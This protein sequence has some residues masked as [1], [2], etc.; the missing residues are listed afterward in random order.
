MTQ[1]IDAPPRNRYTNVYPLKESTEMAVG[2]LGKV[3]NSLVVRIPAAIAR[4]LDLREGEEL[5]INQRDHEIIV[6][7]AR[8]RMAAMLAT[9]PEDYEKGEWGTGPAVGAE[10]FE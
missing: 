4:A 1:K 9:V 5:R 8:S 6:S 10:V 3:G 7:S 2:K